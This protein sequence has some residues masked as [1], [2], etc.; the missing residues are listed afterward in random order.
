MENYAIMEYP[1]FCVVGDRG[2]GK[3]LTATALAYLYHT[4]DH[5]QVISNYTIKN[6][7]A[8]KITFKELY[9]LW[10]NLKD[11][12]I[13]LDE[14]HIGADA[15]NFFNKNVRDLTEFITQL[16]KRHITLIMTTQRVQ[17]L[18]KRLRD[19]I[20]Y[21]LQCTKLN[22]SL[23]GIQVFNMRVPDDESFVKEFAIDGTQFYNWYD[24]DEI[25][26]LEKEPEKPK[27]AKVNKL[28]NSPQ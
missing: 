26:T 15:Y 25:I 28:A 24:T 20:D 16:R 1:I 22:D 12:V 19:M 11:C 2:E 8:T 9:G 10:Q 14:V 18:A 5:Q 6:M 7:D 17:T 4:I 21:T 27:K 23:I 3:T 13:V